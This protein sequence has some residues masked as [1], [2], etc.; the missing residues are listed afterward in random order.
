MFSQGAWTGTSKPTECHFTVTI[1]QG[2][3]LKSRNKKI[4]Q[5]YERCLVCDTEFAHT[6]SLCRG[7]YNL[8]L[9]VLHI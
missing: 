8:Y 1:I 6:T 7:W 2:P 4:V 9:L 3:H 5:K